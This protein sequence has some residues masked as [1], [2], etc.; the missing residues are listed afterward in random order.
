MPDAT[1]GAAAEAA[2]GAASGAAN[3]FHPLRVVE[4]RPETDDAVAVTLRPA[5]EDAERFRFRPGQHLTLRAEIGG[6]EVRRNYSLFVPPHEGELRIAIKRVDGGVFSDWATRV[7]RPGG[8]VEAM[9]PRG[10]FTWSFDPAQRRSY[11][12]FAGGSGITPILS[13]VA[14]G[15]AMEPLS[16]FTLLYGNRT[17]SSVMFLEELAA[18]KDRYLARF[19][20]YHFLTME[21][22]D[23]DLFNGRLDAA[24]I[25]EVLRSLVDPAHVDAAFVCGPEAMMEAAEHALVDAG[26]P[27]DAVLLERFATG[28]IVTAEGTAEAEARRE[29]TRRAEGVRMQVTL[30]G[31]RR[32][33]PFD[34]EEGNILDSARAAGLPAPYACKAGVCATCRAKLV[35]G[36]VEMAANYGLSKEEVAQ[37]YILTCQSVPKGDGVVVDYDA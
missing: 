2:T 4:V 16:R 15:L 9:P 6:K 24:R 32:T 7:L 28:R 23:I 3:R 30:D 18:L 34:A 21:A 13:L 12:A 11:V 27:A 31:R 33:V 37:G 35:S 25:A 29:A 14:T 36:E 20:L 10:H 5:A 8:T 22:D 19:Q 1:P 17:S 26:L